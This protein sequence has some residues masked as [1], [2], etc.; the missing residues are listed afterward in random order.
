VKKLMQGSLAILAVV[1]LV[2]AATVT[3]AGA[4][5]PATAQAAK[6][7]K[8]GKKGKKGAVAAKK[9]K[10][11][12]GKGGP[13]ATGPSLPTAEWSCGNPRH[14]GMQTKAGN[15]YTVNN[16]NPG[17][18]TYDPGTGIVNFQGGSYSFAF[19]KYYPQEQALEIYQNVADPPL[20]VGDYLWTCSH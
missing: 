1:G 10:K 9:C 14:S 15:V 3:P 2:A 17:T 7:K 18:Y 19:G 13:R 11:K 20:A 6:K 12:K 8:C 5:G 16:G 4:D